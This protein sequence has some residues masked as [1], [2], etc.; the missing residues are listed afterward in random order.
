MAGSQQGNSIST[1]EGSQAI[2]TTA[3]FSEVTV[4]TLNILVQNLMTFT[5]MD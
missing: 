1:F 5:G 4:N 2:V 3:K